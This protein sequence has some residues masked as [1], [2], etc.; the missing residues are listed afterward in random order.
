MK[1]SAHQSVK[2]PR[3]TNTPG[4]GEIIPEPVFHSTTKEDSVMKCWLTHNKSKLQLLAV[5]SVSA[6][7]VLSTAAVMQACRLVGEHFD[8]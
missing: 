4:A 2:M 3:C 1:L 5:V 6:V 8:Y 7:V